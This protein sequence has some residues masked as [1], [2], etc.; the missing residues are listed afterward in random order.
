MRGALTWSTITL[1]ASVLCFTSIC[2]PI[3]S[4]IDCLIFTGLVYKVLAQHKYPGTSLMIIII[5]GLLLC[6][7]PFPTFS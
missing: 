3:V 5:T 2:D 7:F 4:L 6:I 1:N